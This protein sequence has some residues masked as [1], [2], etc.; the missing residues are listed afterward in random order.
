MPPRILAAL[1]VVHSERES[2]A[3]EI[4]I[5]PPRLVVTSAVNRTVSR[6]DT[7]VLRQI[8][9][10]R[11]RNVDIASVGTKGYA[12]DVAVKAPLGILSRRV[13]RKESNERKWCVPVHFG[14]AN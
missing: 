8:K 10:Q 12:A 5:G 7:D 6:L 2:R 4:Q 3:A 11:S 1:L 13:S 9:S 14:R